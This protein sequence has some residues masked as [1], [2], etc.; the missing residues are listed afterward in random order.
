MA[1]VSQVSNWAD[2]TIIFYIL[3][4]LNGEPTELENLVLPPEREGGRAA[5][6]KLFD[7]ISFYWRGRQ[8]GADLCFER[9]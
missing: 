4:M 8:G 1:A 6:I 3:S 7:F 9:K 5:E 2:T